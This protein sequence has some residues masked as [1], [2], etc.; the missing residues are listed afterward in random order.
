MHATTTTPIQPSR[1]PHSHPRRSFDSPIEVS[2]A[3][4]RLALRRDTR[5][6][7]LPFS[8]ADQAQVRAGIVVV[9]A[10]ALLL[11]VSGRL[12]LPFGPHRPS[13]LPGYAE[14]HYDPEQSS[15]TYGPRGSQATDRWNVA[16][17][18]TVARDL[19]Q[20][21]V[22]QAALGYPGKPPKEVSCRRSHTL[23]GS[24]DRVPQDFTASYNCTLTWPSGTVRK[25]CAYSMY[26]RPFARATPQT[27]EAD[28]R[29][30][31]SAPLTPPSP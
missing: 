1:S 14:D 27:C 26:G 19:K 7:K 11:A 9:L 22:H 25:W 24:N 5:F 8:C 12:T 2:D 30:L 3:L 23:D 31:P 10:L 13:P 28:S 20:Y 29:E 4:V 18:S 6:L 16:R 17:P 15:P 21:M